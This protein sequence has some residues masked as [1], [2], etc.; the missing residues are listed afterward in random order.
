MTPGLRTS[1]VTTSSSPS[2]S[3]PETIRASPKSADML[4]LQNIAVAELEQL[5]EDC[6]CTTTTSGSGG[7]GPSRNSKITNDHRQPF[8]TACRAL[9]QELDGNNRCVDCDR[10]NPEWAAVSYGA[11]DA[12]NVAEIT[13]ACSTVRS[14]TMDHWNYREVVKMLEGGNR[15][16]QSFFQRHSLT[17]EAIAQFPSDTLT[18]DNI[19]SMRYKT[20]AALFYRKHLEH[21]VTNLIEQGNYKGRRQRK[22]RPL[23]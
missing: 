1:G 5:A 4:S 22:R 21:H 23:G 19:R 11:L 3:F 7:S 15:Q 20:K 16:L 13:A 9:L 18:V 17:T 12:Y 2:S 14:I 8:P 10:K 6:C